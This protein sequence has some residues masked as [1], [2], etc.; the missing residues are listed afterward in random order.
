MLNTNTID[1]TVPIPLYYQ[2]KTLILAEI[3]AG[4][5]KPDEIIP[6][7]A[8]L[9]E[10]FD[11]SRTTVRQA[12]LELVNEGYLYR[13][14]S[15]GTFVAHPRIKQD[16]I[17]RLESFNDQMTR[18]GK[19]P[20]TEVLNISVSKPTPEQASILH[21]AKNEE[22]I[23]LFRKRSAD[24]DPIVIIRT[25]LPYSK[26]SFILDGHDFSKEQ[27]YSILGHSAE[28]TVVKID[29][30]IEAV[31]ATR[32]DAKLLNYKTGKAI[33]RTHSIGYNEAGVP[34]E[35]SIAHY[36]GDHSSFEV[37]VYNK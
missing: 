5:Y 21:L 10:M 25:C 29:R 24:G 31:E 27:L 12:I 33:Q 26:C 11:I 23:Q 2:L 32:E 3:K 20:S 7:E 37:T 16:F 30:V 18:L 22:V 4:N 15:K 14:K 34:I 17:K 9:S 36:R 19:T 35:Y 28:T 1:K 8:E 13:I 6:T